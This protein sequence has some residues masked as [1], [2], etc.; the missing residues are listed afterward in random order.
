MLPGTR[1]ATDN[2]LVAND[3]GHSLV[4]AEWLLPNSKDAAHGRGGTSGVKQHGTRAGKQNAA[5]IQ[6]LHDSL[7]HFQ[8]G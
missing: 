1:K 2:H 4:K 6:T 5:A 7:P 8:N 3:P